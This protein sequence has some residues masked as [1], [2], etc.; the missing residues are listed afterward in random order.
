MMESRSASLNCLANRVEGQCLAFALMLL[1]TLPIGCR[2]DEVRANADP[3][4]IEIKAVVQPARSMLITAQ[5]DGQVRTITVREGT[6]IE[7]GQELVQLTNPTV[8]RDA[9]SA[10]I[11]LEWIDARQKRSGRPSGPGPVQP[12]DG[13]EIATRILA[14]RKV[15][16]EKMQQLRKTNDITARDLE[17]AEIEYL[18]AQR[19]YNNER[20]AAVMAPAAPRDDR[21]LLRIEREKAI[22]D[23]R[24]AADRR[25]LLRIVS[26]MSGIVTRVHVSPGQA[27]FPRD[28]IA[29]VSDVAH[30]HVRGD[31]APE[32]LRYL[33]PGMPVDVKVF[34]VPPRAFSDEIEY[35]IPMQGAGSESRAATVVVTI[36]NPDGSLQ[37]NTQALITLRSLR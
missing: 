7:A 4:P 32:L 3:P 29:D 19:D 21:T 6:K 28:S 25:S 26:P 10:R 24:F 5:I 31:V 1:T 35:V 22:A 33:R 9:E 27:V 34:S 8:E 12:R 20:R 18:A 17:Q 36:P 14:L 23:G 37:P 15:R 13:L 30:L 2:Q 16:F 11:Q